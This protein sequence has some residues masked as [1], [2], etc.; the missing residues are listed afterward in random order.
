MLTAVV[1]SGARIEVN[2]LRAAEE[3][4]HAAEEHFDPADCEFE[5][6]AGVAECG[7]GPGAIT[8]E[9][10]EIAW[11]GGAF[12]V[13]ALVTRYFLYPRLKRS[14]DARYAHIRG[15]HE[16]ADAMRAAATA[17][18]ASYESALASVKA[19]ANERIDAARHTL[20]SERTAKLAEANARIAAK[21]E[22]A[23]EQARIAREA[24]RDGV[25]AA[26]ADV[27]GRTVELS[28]GK[29]PD[30]ASVRSAVDASM[31]VGAAS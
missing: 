29:A 16:Q 8:P 25:A 30:A 15:G 31:S 28:I 11:G 6:E 27:A 3:G 13:F 5:P 9:V 2:I 24:A 14:M 21:R 22:A 7:A 19:E 12:I 10:K 17:E 1:T 23:N 4:D 26:A 18:V 20:E